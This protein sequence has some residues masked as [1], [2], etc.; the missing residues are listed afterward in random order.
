MQFF[1]AQE[2]QKRQKVYKP[3]RTLLFSQY[4]QQKRLLDRGVTQN[5]VQQ[6]PSV[7]KKSEKGEPERPVVDRHTNFYEKQGDKAPDLPDERLLVYKGVHGAMYSLFTTKSHAMFNFFW[8]IASVYAAQD[9]W[10]HFIHGD[11]FGF[12]VKSIGVLIFVYFRAFMQ[13]GLSRRVYEIELVRRHGQRY[14]T[15]I[16]I[17]NCLGEKHIFPL[18]QVEIADLDFLEKH[19]SFA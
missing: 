1:V 16:Q 7:W 14:A 19:C 15:E 18:D 10:T 4:N 3:S 8:P 12:A 11:T 5:L 17:M 6:K 9:A 13:K 2:T